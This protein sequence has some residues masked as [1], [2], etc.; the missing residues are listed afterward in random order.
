MLRIAVFSVLFAANL[1][2]FATPARSA[3]ILLLGHDRRIQS[4]AF[5]ANEEGSESQ[6]TQLVAPDSGPFDEFVS[7]F[8]GVA[9]TGCEG[10]ATQN[11]VVTFA[12]IQAYGTRWAFGERAGV[13]T[14]AYASGN[15]EVA[16][17]FSIE[18]VRDYSIQ[19]FVESSGE[20][21]SSI[22]LSRPFQTLHFYSTSSSPRV[23]FDDTGTL[24]PGIYDLNIHSSGT[25]VTESE[26]SELSS[27]AF[28]LHFLLDSATGAPVVDS[29]ALAA[30]P[31]P[32]T[33]ETRL[34]VPED[35]TAVRIFDLS[36]RQVRAL[37]GHGPF[38]WDGRDQNGRDLS[39]GVYWMCAVG[40]EATDPVQI[41]RMR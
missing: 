27:G 19:G 11:S 39:S 29:V 28:E 35:A 40:A 13:G 34:V 1:F 15:S 9:G 17:R 41:V 8:A 21:I 25:I 10:S 36:G 3:G 18:T 33:N 32:F 4:S 6:V 2:G 30:F 7:S 23:D 16:L 31:N 37:D 20:G 38:V 14:T 12:A 5:A 26:G 22:A 24:Q